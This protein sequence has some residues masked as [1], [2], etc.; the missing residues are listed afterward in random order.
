MKKFWLSALIIA[1]VAPWFAEAQVQVASGT[2]QISGKVKWIYSYMRQSD[3]ALNASNPPAIGSPPLDPAWVPPAGYGAQ[4]YGFDGQGIE[5]FATSS[6]ELDINGT[7]GDKVAYVIELQSSAGLDSIPFGT[8]S[9]QNR[10]SNPAELG[11]IGVRQAKVMF[12]NVIPMTT[13]TVGTFMLPV[14]VYQT[15]ATNDWDLIHLPLIN[16]VQFGNPQNGNYK[17][18]G[19]G[20]QATG[21]NFA[22]Q[23]ADMVELDVSYFNGN[24]GNGANDEADLEKSWLINLKVMPVEGAMISIAYLTEGWQED[25][26][27]NPSNATQEHNASGYVVSAAY[28]NKKLEINGDWMTMTAK[29]YQLER[30][31]AGDRLENLTWTGYQITAG[32]WVT[33]AIEPIIRYEWADP[34]TA[35]SKKTLR[36]I[37]PGYTPL[38]S[39]YDALTVLTAGVNWRVTEN[40]EVAVNYLWIS[41][42]GDDMDMTNTVAG[43]LTPLHG[44]KYQALDNDTLLIQVQVWQ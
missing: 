6:V 11:A 42:Q 43:V 41:E 20:W 44:G 40:S 39:E 28:D 21:V 17:P 1:A 14:S 12:K 5:Q 8:N 31:G 23:P 13:V 35:N 18:I 32:Y 24:V 7:L 19:L 25:T 37:T 36:T 29:D 4:Y 34:N 15:R 26:T 38:P 10:A 30:K 9:I 33:D 27:H 16:T 22:I 2:M 3:D